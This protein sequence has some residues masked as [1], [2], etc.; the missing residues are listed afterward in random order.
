MD[1]PLS[2]IEQRLATR[3]LAEDFLQAFG[4]R[5]AKYLASGMNWD[6]AVS[7]HIG[8][9]Q[10]ENQKLRDRLALANESESMPLSSGGADV[11]LPDKRRGMESRIKGA[12]L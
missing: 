3:Q 9:L 6:Q 8:W 1:R 10:Y 7:A 12:N 5:A 4:P 11:G 2:Q